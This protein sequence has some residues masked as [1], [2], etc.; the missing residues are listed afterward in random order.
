MGAGVTSP[1]PSDTARALP[2]SRAPVDR[3]CNNLNQINA[4]TVDSIMNSI[5]VTG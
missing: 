1:G 3:I 5:E 4:E 2:A